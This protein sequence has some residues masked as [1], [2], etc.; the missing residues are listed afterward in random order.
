MTEF[1]FWA[2][3]NADKRNDR[4]IEEQSLL[5]LAPLSGARS[6]RV[7]A[8]RFRPS[9]NLLP[10]QSGASS[11]ADNHGKKEMWDMQ[12]RIFATPLK[13]QGVPLSK[14]EVQGNRLSLFP[15]LAA[16]S[17][18]P[19]R[20]SF[21]AI[22]ECRPRSGPA[23]SQSARNGLPVHCSGCWTVP[24][25]VAALACGP[26]RSNKPF[27]L[28]VVPASGVK[29]SDHVQTKQSGVFRNSKGSLGDAFRKAIPASELFWNFI[30]FVAMQSSAF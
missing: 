18:V 16:L 1:R 3:L 14:R 23:G 17:L 20:T 13:S 7:S 6:R 2:G 25:E 4:W 21:Y 22:Q 5:G 10:M 27:D 9:P 26:V 29:L 19:T 15:V 28:D 8:T 24:E 12:L 11:R 30:G